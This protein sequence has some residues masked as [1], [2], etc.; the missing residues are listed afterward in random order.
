LSIGEQPFEYRQ[1]VENLGLTPCEVRA[2]PLSG[3]PSYLVRDAFHNPKKASEQQ[4]LIKMI[5]F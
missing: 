1:T 4:L 3:M 2:L 5:K